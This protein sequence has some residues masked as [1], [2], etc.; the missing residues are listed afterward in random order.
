MGL[1]SKIIEASFKAGILLISAIG[2]FYARRLW[3]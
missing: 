3:R 2:W 1:F